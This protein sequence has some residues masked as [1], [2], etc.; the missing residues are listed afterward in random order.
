MEG[1][2]ASSLHLQHRQ[3]LNRTHQLGLDDLDVCQVVHQLQEFV[4]GEY[5][6][7][8]GEVEGGAGEGIA[9]HDGVEVLVL[10]VAY[11]AWDVQGFKCRCLIAEIDQMN[12]ALTHV[13]GLEILQLPAQQIDHDSS[14]H[15]QPYGL[16]YLEVGL[17]CDRELSAHMFLQLGHLL[18]STDALLDA[19]GILGLP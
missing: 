7:D 19:I 1:L 3:R 8:E 2:P 14:L 5:P 6:Q 16:V 13:M 17:F 9:A 18:T 15:L 11:F 12:L 4:A 10:G